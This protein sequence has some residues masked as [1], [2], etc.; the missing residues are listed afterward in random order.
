MDLYDFLMFLIKSQKILTLEDYV[1]VKDAFFRVEA[2]HRRMKSMW[3]DSGI[4]LNHCD[5]KANPTK[6]AYLRS[7]H[8]LTAE[9]ASLSLRAQN[10][11][12]EMLGEW[13]ERNPPMII[14][15]S[16]PPSQH[17]PSPPQ[18]NKRGFGD[19][20]KDREKSKKGFGSGS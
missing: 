9:S 10:A 19:A 3:I 16:L 18:N 1:F 15:R 6:Y 5:R 8:H 12:A 11:C 7:F 20:I 14:I 13:E 2:L 17:Q 4:T